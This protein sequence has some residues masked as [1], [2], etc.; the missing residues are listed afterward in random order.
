MTKLKEILKPHYHTLQRVIKFVRRIGLKNHDFTIISNNCTAGYVYQHFG[1]KYNTPTAGIFFTTE[2][3]LRLI[4]NPKR[5]LENCNLDFIEP[6]NSKNYTLL[7]DTHGYGKYPVAT[8]L[9]IEIYFMHY[10]SRKEA[11]QI[12][13]R[14]SSRIDYNN[15]FFLLTE[16]EYFTAK[17]LH[18]FCKLPTKYK[19]CLTYNDYHINNQFVIQNTQVPVEGGNIAWL[20]KIIVNSIK[21]KTILNDM[22]SPKKY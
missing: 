8:L 20:P 6:K 1:L 2:D 12:F 3:Y 13:I 21:W 9:D 14:R 16:N 18:E 15:L 17:S 11:E 10:H 4:K 5:Y 22:L 7:K 19:L